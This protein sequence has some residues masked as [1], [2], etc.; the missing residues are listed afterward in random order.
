M[1]RRWWAALLFAVVCGAVLWVLATRSSQ[2]PSDDRT[3]SLTVVAPTSA[4]TLDAPPSIVLITI[5]TLRA[6]HLGAYGHPLETSP[7]L[8]AFAE[9]AVVFEGVLAAGGTTTPSHLSLL[10]GLYPHQHGVLGNRTV[11]RA[12]FRSAPGVHTVA[13][14]LARSGYAT[15]GVVSATPVKRMTGMAAGFGAW[16]QPGRP[17]WPCD[18]TASRA[19]GWLRRH[20]V[21]PFF[22]WVHFW[23]PHAPYWP[24]AKYATLFRGD[25]TYEML[26]DGRR[27]DPDMVPAVSPR[28]MLRRF[29][30]PKGGTLPEIDRPA[31]VDLLARY[32]G[33]VRHVDECVGQVFAQ[34][35]AMGVWDDAIV[36]VTADHG[37][38]LGQHGWLAHNTM[39]HVGLEV[40][41]MMRFPEGIAEPARY[42]V[43]A[44]GVDVMPT[45]LAR[46]D[47][48]ASDAFLA[49]AAGEDLLSGSYAR[50]TAFALGEPG[51]RRPK[52]ARTSTL[53][54]GDWKLQQRVGKAPRL[55]DLAA[56]PLELTD[57]AGQHPKRVERMRE[58]VETLLTD[59]PRGT[60]EEVE[61]TPELAAELEALGYIGE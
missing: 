61:V 18:R 5:D 59:R 27:V 24:G 25:P 2:V 51:G 16:V 4:G 23:E 14:L 47:S 7:N 20:E 31:M 50:N 13:E 40:P 46:F 54:V 12:P 10:T 30:E 33:D 28:W 60:I 38:S 37:Q 52:K 43:V 11:L 1:T 35:R 26:M 45:V 15:A 56:D 44:S 39:S 8:D 22:L 36:V 21:E 55:F 17:S 58:Q 41:L 57:V 9:E 53:Q 49:Q 6:D 32:D 3:S 29:F 19:V 48:P 42:E 34:L